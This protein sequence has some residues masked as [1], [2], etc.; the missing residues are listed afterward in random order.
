LQILQKGLK[1]TYILHKVTDTKY[2]ICRVLNE[3][4]SKQDADAELVKLLTHKKTEEEL[5]KEY[6]KKETY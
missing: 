3:Y 2:T 1:K 4:N 6:T 5:L